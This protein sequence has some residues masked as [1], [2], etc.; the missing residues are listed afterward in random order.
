MLRQV[1]SDRVLKAVN[2]RF[3]V[4]R[5]PACRKIAGWFET[6]VNLQPAALG[7]HLHYWRFRVSLGEV[8][9]HFQM[10]ERRIGDVT[11]LK[12]T[13]R[14]VLGD[15]DRSFRERV[16]ALIQEGRTQFILNVHDV[17]YIDSC[18]IGVLVSNFVSLRGRGGII[19]LV[20]PSERCQRVLQ[21]THLLPLFEI[22]ESDQA[23]I[24]S[25]AD[26]IAEAAP[27]MNV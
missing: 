9:D 8:M 26:A 10:A 1:H 19:K 13:G 21:L 4:A 12:L 7:P 3:F 2:S 11:V 5:R 6:I 22:Y 27:G 14:L 25:F 24:A 23:A 17:S 18:G 15:G 20:C 16:G